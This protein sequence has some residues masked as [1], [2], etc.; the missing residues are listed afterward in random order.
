MID[1][2]AGSAL[3]QSSCQSCHGLEALPSPQVAPSWADVA[4][5]YRGDQ[6]GLATYLTNP[7]ATAPRMD[8]AVN[9]FGPMPNMGL[10]PKQAQDLAAFIAGTDFNAA[11]W[12]AQAGGDDP[13]VSPLELAGNWARTTKG[14]LGKNL[15]AALAAGGPEGAVPFCNER[16]LPLTDSMSTAL[17]VRIRRVS[18]RPRN[19][20][21]RAT[22]DAAEYLARQ[23]GQT[24]WTPELITAGSHHT[25][26]IPITTDGMCLQC[27]GTVGAQIQPGTARLIQAHYPADEATGYAENQLRGAWVVEFDAE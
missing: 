19:P 5:A 22:G 17:N 16:A 24:A 12:S 14:V 13:S 7:G 11:G 15:M 6:A 1:A 2:G 21:N 9:R 23:G 25:A 27:H 4:A 26:F 8:D 20:G 10:S 18:D 3:I